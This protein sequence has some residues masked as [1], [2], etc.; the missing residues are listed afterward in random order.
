[1]GKN[2]LWI[3]D[4]IDDVLY[5]M[6]L[7]FIKEG[8][9]IDKVK[10][11]SDA[12]KKIEE[13]NLSKYDFIIIDIMLPHGENFNMDEPYEGLEILKKLMDEKYSKE[14]II[15]YTIVYEDGVK[16]KITEE[17]G[18]KHF[19]L[20]EENPSKNFLYKKIKEIEG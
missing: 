6:Q 13:G 9:Y 7:P 15:V 18:I 3:E 5:E 14:R 2:I 20:K 1:M 12:L 17:W 19:Y 10:K 8:Y 4:E 11:A 16:R